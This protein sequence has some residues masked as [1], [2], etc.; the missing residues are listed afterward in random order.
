MCRGRANEIRIVMNQLQRTLLA[1]GTMAMILGSYPAQTAA[2]TPKSQVIALT[3]VEQS[4]RPGLTNVYRDAARVLFEGFK[5]AFRDALIKGMRGS[6]DEKYR[7]SV[8]L[9][10]RTNSLDPQ[11][12]AVYLKDDTKGTQR[13]EVYRFQITL[14]TDLSAEASAAVAKL[15]EIIRP[16]ANGPSIKAALPL[17]TRVAA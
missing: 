17:A 6:V 1:F 8:E 12:L 10:A 4:E 13:K 15:A 7:I 14:Q 5:P 9:L 3:F 16:S 11:Y 2:Q